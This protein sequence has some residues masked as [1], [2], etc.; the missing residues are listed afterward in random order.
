MFSQETK[1]R[2]VSAIADQGLADDLELRLHQEYPSSAEAAQAALD[3]HK[4]DTVKMRE[5]LV[6]ALAQKEAGDEL[7]DRLEKADAILKAIADGEEISGTPA[8]ASSFEGQVA[9]MTTDVLIQADIEGGSGNDI[10]LSFDGLDDIDTVL[11]AWNLA[12][13]TNTASLIAGD[14][15]QT[16]DD[17]QEI[18]LA[19]GADEIPASD[20][21][22][23]P[24]ISAF[25][26]QSISEST[27][28]RIT[29]ALA[30]EE[31]S[32]EF[33]AQHDS[34]VTKMND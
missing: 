20:E 14:G 33:K 27:M 4:E 24:A 31:A 19:G 6:V 2:L 34:W 16:P 10:V 15:S 25:G 21:N 32:K 29:V 26:T 22:T 17:L 30:S 12:N 1:Q 13:T 23:I 9:G 7:V 28:E 18:Q 5:W 11:A 8:I 3:S